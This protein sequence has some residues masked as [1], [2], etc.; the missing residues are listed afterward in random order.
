M[1]RL[2]RLPLGAEFSVGQFD[3]PVR[4][5]LAAREQAYM[6]MIDRNPD[7][8]TVLRTVIPPI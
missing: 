3:G 8:L 4:S 6:L 1:F 7:L 5:V 2:Y